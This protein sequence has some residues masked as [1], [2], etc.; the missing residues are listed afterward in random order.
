M[1]NK[2]N[3]NEINIDTSEFFNHLAATQI[4]ADIFPH[5]IKYTH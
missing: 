2:N 1:E 5:H 4:C 3:K